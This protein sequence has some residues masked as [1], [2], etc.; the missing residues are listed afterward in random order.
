MH[1]CYDQSSSHFP[2]CTSK[3]SIQSTIRCQWWF[4]TTIYVQFLM[5]RKTRIQ[6]TFYKVM[7]DNLGIKMTP[8]K[9]NH[10][11]QY[12]SNNERTQIIFVVDWIYI[13]IWDHLYIYNVCKWNGCCHRGQKVNA[14]ITVTTVAYMWHKKIGK[15]TSFHR[16]RNII[17]TLIHKN[18]KLWFSLLRCFWYKKLVRLQQ[19]VILLCS[20]HL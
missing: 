20:Q 12:Q 1:S 11:I 10:I 2:Y 3:E 13:Y 9:Y 6:L 19:K 7:L 8:Q 14:N 17:Y 18:L 5:L 15:E 4:S 16:Y